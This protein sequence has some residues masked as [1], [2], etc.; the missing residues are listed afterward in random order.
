MSGYDSV[1]SNVSSRVRKVARDG[2]DV[3]L[4][5]MAVP[6]LKTS[7][8]KCSAA[9]SGA[10]NR[11]LNEAVAAGRAKSSATWKVG[12]VNERAKVRRCTSVCWCRQAE[13]I[14]TSAS[15]YLSQIAAILNSV[16][17]QLLLIFKT[18]DLLRGIEWS[19]R[20]GTESSHPAHRTQTAFITMSRCCVRAV[21]RE[22]AGL[23][24]GRL[25]CALRSATQMYWI[26]LKLSAYELYLRL[27]DFVARWVP[28]VRSSPET[29]YVKRLDEM[30][31]TT[32]F[33]V[34][35]A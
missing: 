17:R 27:K 2:A 26:L 4:Q 9:N 23:C 30:L 8:R 20:G 11:R 33:Q 3:T 22:Q 16:H 21:G 7:N 29:V 25:L 13:I 31:Q 12:N 34:S 24:R 10:V 18:N 5:L 28:A 14:K 32:E 19:L 6:H 1:N 35:V 15:N